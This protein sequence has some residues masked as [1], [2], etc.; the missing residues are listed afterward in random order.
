MQHAG[1]N[2]LPRFARKQKNFPC[3]IMEISQQF[4]NIVRCFCRTPRDLSLRKLFWFNVSRI[5]TSKIFFQYFWQ[6]HNKKQR[7]SRVS[8]IVSILPDDRHDAED[9][10]FLALLL[11]SCSHSG[12][13]A[14]PFNCHAL[15]RLSRRQQAYL[16]ANASSCSAQKVRS[17]RRNHQLFIFLEPCAAEQ[18]ATYEKQR[19]STANWCCA[20]V[21]LF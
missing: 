6:L 10:W 21:S 19:L 17:I 9:C 3:H 7:R 2:F 14:L 20:I 4:H 12:A 13:A 16:P 8:V 18:T 1:S 5:P 11:S 15:W